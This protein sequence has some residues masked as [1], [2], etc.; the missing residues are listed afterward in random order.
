[1]SFYFAFNGKSREKLHQL[2]DRQKSYSYVPP[3]AIA[4]V[5]EAIDEFP[6]GTFLKVV[7]QGHKA[8]TYSPLT[9]TIAATMT[10]EVAPLF[11]SE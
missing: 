6:D 9:S 3:A 1:M 2:A 10:I 8:Q 4:F 5:K 11:E 7:A